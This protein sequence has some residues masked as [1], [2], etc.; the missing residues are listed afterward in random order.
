M[1]CCRIRLRVFFHHLRKRTWMRSANHD[2][3]NEANS[4][5]DDLVAYHEKT[6][7]NRGVDGVRGEHPRGGCSL[8]PSVTFPRRL[9]WTRLEQVSWLVTGVHTRPSRPR[10]VAS[11]SIVTYSCGAAS[12]YTEFPWLLPIRSKERVS[13]YV[14][15][16]TKSTHPSPGQYSSKLSENRPRGLAPGEN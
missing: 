8:L 2:Y 1:V 6:P 10:S 14:G 11:A 13:T 16:L 5:A 9:L 12:A 4:E 3:S 7:A 15:N